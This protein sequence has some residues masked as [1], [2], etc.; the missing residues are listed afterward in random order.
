MGRKGRKRPPASPYGLARGSQKVKKD[1]L[2]GQC[3]FENYLIDPE[4]NLLF[5]PL[6]FLQFSVIGREDK[7][8]GPDFSKIRGAWISFTRPWVLDLHRK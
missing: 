4:I 2:N 1:Y 7:Q 8:G 5:P 3:S 6:L